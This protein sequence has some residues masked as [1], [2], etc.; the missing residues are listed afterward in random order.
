MTTETKMT[1][2]DE[3]LP[4]ETRTERRVA[5]S[6]DIYE[7][8]DE[9]LLLADMP[10]VGKDD[11]QVRI[12]KDVLHVEGK[13]LFAENQKGLL[14]CELAPCS[15]ARS[16]SIPR[17]IDGDQISASLD[18]GVLTVRLPKRESVKPRQIQVVS[19]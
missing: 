8:Q 17:T 19:G 14:S 5:P 12:D 7:N 11:L 4:E 16:F 3:T 10:G 18:R 2:R 9:I 1:R 13:K 6:V 15:Y